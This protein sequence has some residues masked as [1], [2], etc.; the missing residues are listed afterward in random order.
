V[1][2]DGSRRRTADKVAGPIALVLTIIGGVIGALKVDQLNDCEWYA[3]A[4]VPL[5]IATVLVAIG[6]TTVM[7]GV[8]RRAIGLRMMRSLY[9]AIA[10]A[11]VLIVCGWLSYSDRY[12]GCPD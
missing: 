6:I 9:W 11:S 8:G 7:V 1:D 3:G 4:W 12:A 10:I 2:A 5:T